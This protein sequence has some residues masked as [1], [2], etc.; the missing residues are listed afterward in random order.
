MLDLNLRSFLKD[1]RPSG[2]KQDLKHVRATL[3]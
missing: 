1:S 2:F 3:P